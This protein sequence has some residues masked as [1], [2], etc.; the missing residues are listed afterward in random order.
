MAI[1]KIQ[2][3]VAP[4]AISEYDLS[5]KRLLFGALDMPISRLTFDSVCLAS[6]PILT[7]DTFRDACVRRGSSRSYRN[8]SENFVSLS[9]LQ[10]LRDSD[11]A[12]SSPPDLRKDFPQHRRRPA[13]PVMADDDP[14]RPEHTQDMAGVD[15]PERY[16]RIVWV[17]CSE[18]QAVVERV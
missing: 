8:L 1:L 18:D 17:D 4:N 15:P 3:A 14:S 11:H 13:A 12:I 16:L 9:F 6:W 10:Q 2:S 7:S 5:S